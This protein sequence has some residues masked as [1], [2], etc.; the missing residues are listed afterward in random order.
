MRVCGLTCA[1]QSEKVTLRTHDEHQC[2]QSY[3]K[4]CDGDIAS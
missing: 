1:F 2:G 3:N 4:I